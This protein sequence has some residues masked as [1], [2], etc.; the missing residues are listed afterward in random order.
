MKIYGLTVNYLSEPC[1]VDKTPRF[2]YKIES[3]RNGDA[4]KSARIRLFASE[5][6]ETPVWDTGAVEGEQR[7]FIKYDGA[8]LIPVHK[9]FWTVDVTTVLGDTASASG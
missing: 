4:Q 2:S 5:D 6:T 1:G 3:E 7:L 9:Y 8:A